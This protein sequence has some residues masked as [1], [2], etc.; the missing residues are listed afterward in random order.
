MEPPSQT[1]IYRTVGAI[2]LTWGAF[3]MSGERDNLSKEVDGLYKV[4]KESFRLNNAQRYYITFRGPQVRAEVPRE[5]IREGVDTLSIVYFPGHCDHADAINA[6]QVF[7]KPEITT[8]DDVIGELAK[9]SL[10]RDW[11]DT[12]DVLCILD[13]PLP[14]NWDDIIHEVM[15][16]RNIRLLETLAAASHGDKTCGP[17]KQSF[18]NALIWSLDY[19]AYVKERFSVSELA[20]KIRQ[21]PNFPTDQVP[22]HKIQ[23]APRTE[24]IVLDPMMELQDNVGPEPVYYSSDSDWEPPSP[25][26]T[27]PKKDVFGLKKAMMKNKQRRRRVKAL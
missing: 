15:R 8:V 22:V 5:F 7:G 1:I 20:E 4:F 11:K 2:I 17:G 18:T 26:A 13:G 23:N 14:E 3:C 16:K 24:R 6:F 12:S 25:P 19:Y 21:A 9:A 10:A 27:G